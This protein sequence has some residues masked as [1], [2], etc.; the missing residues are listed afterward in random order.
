M[1]TTRKGKPSSILPSLLPIQNPSGSLRR[2]RIILEARVPVREELQT[3]QKRE[4][5]P[6]VESP[7]TSRA[8]AKPKAKNALKFNMGAGNH[9]GKNV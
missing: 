5:E 6:V 4:A 7:D 1:G 3:T 2:W 8:P 9:V